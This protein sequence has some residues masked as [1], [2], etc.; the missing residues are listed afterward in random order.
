MDLLRWN[1]N[2]TVGLRVIDEQHK[3]LFVIIN[4]LIVAFNEQQDR[5]VYEKIFVELIA[6]T[7]YHFLTE[8]KFIVSA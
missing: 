2:Y 7:K 8:K 1:K 6:F 3:R 5:Q 4:D